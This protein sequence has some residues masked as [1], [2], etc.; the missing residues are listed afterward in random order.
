MDRTEE[1][2]TETEHYQDISIWPER[3][4]LSS[5]TVN[6]IDENTH[7]VMNINLEGR[8]EISEDGCEG[9]L[10]VEAVKKILESMSLTSA[11]G[12]DGIQYAIYA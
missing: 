1:Q 9:I 3:I 6:P 11:L 10:D 8:I 4:V 12:P 2:D 7:R 5:S